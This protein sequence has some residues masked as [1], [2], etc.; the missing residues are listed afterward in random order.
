MSFCSQNATPADPLS[1][2]RNILTSPLFCK[3]SVVGMR[4]DQYFLLNDAMLSK[5]RP[6]KRGSVVDANDV[7]LVSKSLANSASIF[8]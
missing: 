8:A 2:A 7:D 4:K 6:R 1:R 3:S 5:D